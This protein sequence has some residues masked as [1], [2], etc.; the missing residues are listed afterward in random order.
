MPRGASR[1]RRPS[2]PATIPA[3]AAAR[4]GGTAHM[5]RPWKFALAF[6]AAGAVIVIAALGALFWV[7]F[8]EARVPQR[9]VLELDLTTP[10]L[11]QHPEGPFASPPFQKPM[12]LRHVVEAPHAAA[13]DH[14][15]VG[16]VAR[17]SPEGIGLAGIEELRDAVTAF[18]KSGKPAVAW[19][20]TFGEV[21]PANGAYYLATAF[22]EI[23]IQPSGDVGL[24]GLQ[25]TSPFV[26]GT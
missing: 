20:D 13:D 1:L 21:T 11:E 18:R 25:L 6:F 26:R 3:G 14:Q 9:T 12:R 5:T 8:G 15:V 19:T 7:G 24:T 17:V 4:A 16:L 10:L 2:P 22:S 23:Y